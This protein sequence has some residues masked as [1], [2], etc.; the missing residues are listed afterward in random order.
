MYLYKRTFI[1]LKLWTGKEFSSEK[2]K[3]RE[4]E[5][6][7]EIGNKGDKRLLGTYHVPATVLML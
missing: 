1:E 6:E 2:D 3:K 5:I 7:R 4:R